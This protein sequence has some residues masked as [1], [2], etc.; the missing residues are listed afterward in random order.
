M[1]AFFRDIIKK[2][3]SNYPLEVKGSTLKFLEGNKTEWSIDTN[4]GEVRLKN[5]LVD[6]KFINFKIHAVDF[7]K[8]NGVFTPEILTTKLGEGFVRIEDNNFIVFESVDGRVPNYVN[9]DDV[10][11]MINGI[12]SLHNVSNGFDFSDGQNPSLVCDWKNDIQNKYSKLILWKEQRNKIKDLNEVD[13]LYLKYVNPF[14]KQCET[15]LAI[16]SNPHFEEW[17]EEARNTKTFSY[18]NF[19]E[20]NLAIG[21]DGNF[22][23]LD[24]NLLTV[25]LPISDIQKIL[26]IVMTKQ[27]G[28]KLRLMEKMMSSYQAVNPLKFGQLQLL[29]ADLLFPH[30]FYDTFSAIYEQKEASD[31]VEANQVSKM[32]KMIT[33]ELSKEKVVHAF[34][35]ENKMKE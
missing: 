20:K 24:M 11:I 26:N 30:L 17:I 35:Y 5:V 16:V 9:E 4:I 1:E 34:F 15:S 8:N 6:D 18:Q 28:W 25:D 33:T 12:A 10:I 21:E 31:R 14:L 32:K 27:D 13:Q 7:L 19:E 29:K 22:Y 23:L 2:V 3:I